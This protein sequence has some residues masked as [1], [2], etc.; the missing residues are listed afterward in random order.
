MS[1]RTRS[2]TTRLTVAT[3][4]GAAAAG[5]VAFSLGGREGTGVMAGYLLGASLSGFGAAWQLHLLRRGSD[6]VFVA[7]VSVFLLKLAVILAAALALRYLEP[8]ARVAEWRSFLVAFAAGGSWWSS[9]AS[10]VD[11]LRML[12]QRSV[13]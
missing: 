7:T 4:V 3:L 9:R 13:A 12:K 6:K 1:T 10:S 8:V 2:Q 11:T 5:L